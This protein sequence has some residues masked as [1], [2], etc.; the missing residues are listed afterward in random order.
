MPRQATDKRTDAQRE[1]DDKRALIVAPT[2]TGAIIARVVGKRGTVVRDYARHILGW[3]A[4]DGTDGAKH[5]GSHVIGTDADREALANKFL[6]TR[7]E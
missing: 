2:S 4:N 7:P 5:A 3:Y 1:Y 6:G